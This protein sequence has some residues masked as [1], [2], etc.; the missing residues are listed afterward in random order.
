MRGSSLLTKPAPF[1]TQSIAGSV[2]AIYF[3]NEAEKLKALCVS[4]SS[5]QMPGF[6]KS[7]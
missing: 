4:D 3:L 6:Q 7:F 1:T 2:L 5:D